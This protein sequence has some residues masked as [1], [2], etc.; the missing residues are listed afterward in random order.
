M[1]LHNGK[2]CFLD[3]GC[4]VRSMWPLIPQSSISGY[5][6]SR[7]STVMAQKY[8][9]EERPRY[10]LGELQKRAIRALKSNERVE[11][12]VP[13]LTY[14][15]QCCMCPHF[16]TRVHVTLGMRGLDLRCGRTVAF[17]RPPKSHPKSPLSRMRKCFLLLWSRRSSPKTLPPRT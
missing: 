2:T 17:F 9:Q 15:F 12:F 3:S 10:K 4:F 13:R 14:I 11:A 16:L 7:A 6:T 5:W 1:Q 8:E